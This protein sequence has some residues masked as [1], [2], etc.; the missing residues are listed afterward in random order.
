LQIKYIL[1]LLTSL[2][3]FL[4]L[5]ATL[6]GG[7]G[8]EITVILCL[9]FFIINLLSTFIRS[10]TYKG[11][12]YFFTIINLVFIGFG[13]LLYQ[14]IPGL[15]LNN[16]TMLCINLSYMAFLFG[17]LLG[18]KTTI[19]LRLNPQ[20]ENSLNKRATLPYGIIIAILIGI[21]FNTGSFLFPDFISAIGIGPKLKF[22]I[23]MIFAYEFYFVILFLLIFNDYRLYNNYEKLF[24]IL[25]CV[26]FVLA[27]LIIGVKT[28]IIQLSIFLLIVFFTMTKDYRIPK[29][30]IY[31]CL[32]IL[33][34]ILLSYSL[35]LSIRTLISTQ[36]FVGNI[37]LIDIYM[38]IYD[39]LSI[40]NLD[41]TANTVSFFERIS[42]ISQIDILINNETNLE[43][44]VI[45]YFQYLV[46]LLLPGSIFPNAIPPA[47]YFKV[48]YL[49]VS[50]SEASSNYRSAMLPI[51][52]E[53]F[54]L[55]GSFALIIIFFIGLSYIK[56]LN[57]LLRKNFF[58][59]LALYAFSMQV[60][61]YLI[62]GMGFV[63]AIQFIMYSM[64][65]PGL[66]FVILFRKTFR[67]LKNTHPI[68]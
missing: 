48:A 7:A 45:N 59:H 18:E 43:K 31:I 9:W 34:L 32:L 63:A 46:N 33:P 30:T 27:K 38:N 39:N 62:F 12:Y 25:L 2:L 29:K 35:G 1:R 16:L 53:V 11:L 44:L 3:L 4:F 50:L 52:G 65:I 67:L 22:F 56:I 6:I 13:I 47:V 14:I 61:Y 15:I 5:L 40:S 19:P 57:Y 42:M 36:Y 37:N 41:V 64:I 26:I 49:N 55:I 54:S 28:G 17:M 8:D 66:I 51:Y 24:L 10:N 60:L 23:N 21:I 20:W 58:S 68:L